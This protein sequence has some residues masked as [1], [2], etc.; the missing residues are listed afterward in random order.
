MCIPLYVSISS[1]SQPK[2][3][4]CV[5]VHSNRQSERV[6]FTVSWVRNVKSEGSSSLQDPSCVLGRCFPRQIEAQRCRLGPWALCV[7]DPLHEQ[8]LS[9]LSRERVILR[10]F[11]VCHQTYLLHFFLTVLS[12]FPNLSKNL[13][14]FFDGSTALWSDIS[15]VRPNM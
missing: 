7:H 6:F 5:N 1:H 13:L 14:T 9:C 15:Q 11:S 3:V 2:N 4:C 12:R 8:A 10:G